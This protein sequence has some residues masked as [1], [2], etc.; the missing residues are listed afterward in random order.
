ML[1]VQERESEWIRTHS[2]PCGVWSPAQLSEL[3]RCPK[4]SFSDTAG[5]RGEKREMHT[6]A[7]F[8]IPSLAVQCCSNIVEISNS[9]FYKDQHLENIRKLKKR[10][11]IR[12]VGIK[13][14]CQY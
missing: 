11:Y 8:S 3:N 6:L 14:H 10:D 1:S 2:Q 13:T 12:N 7:Q 4:C 5:S 9:I